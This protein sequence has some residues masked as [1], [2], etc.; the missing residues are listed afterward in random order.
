MITKKSLIKDIKNM[1]LLP[2]DSIMIHSSMKSIGQVEGG[3]DTVVDVFMEYFSDGMVMMPTHTWAQMNSDYNVF[4]PEHEPACVGILPNIFMKR[5]GVVRSL[6]P[7]HS[8]AVYGKGAEEYILNEENCTTPCTP[9]GCWDR[10]RTIDAKILLIGVNHIKNTYI[11]SVEEVFDVQ[12][13]L[14]EQP[15]EYQIKMPDKILKKVSVH[16]HYNPYT[17]HISESYDKLTKA[18]YE[19]GAAKKVKFG[20]A[21]CILCEAKKLYE[22]VAKV[23]SHQI[24]CLMDCEEVPKEYWMDS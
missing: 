3:A 12:E 6:H 22:I 20:E 17:A 7:T 8:M 19:T 18:F 9:G 24:N 4:D 21:D 23:L 16:K 2:T 11:H 10:L 13:R 1:F 14:S 15:I 5:E